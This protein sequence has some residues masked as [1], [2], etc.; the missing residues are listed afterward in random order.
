LIFNVDE[1]SLLRRPAG[2]YR[3]AYYLRENNWDAEVIDFTIFWP[4]EKLKQL[5]RQRMSD[6]VKFIGFSYLFVDQPLTSI[7][8]F[9]EWIKKEYPNVKIL[10]GSPNKYRFNH[11]YIDYN[12]DGF[13][14]IALLE[15]LK[16]LFSNGSRPAFTLFS[17]AGKNISANKN[18]PAFP[19]SN[20]NII[21]EDRDFLESH[22]WLGI[23]FSR[24]CKF[25]CAFCNYPV[26]G[27]KGDYSRD[28]EDFDS[29]MRN[30]YDRFG[31]TKY[32]VADETF[33]DRTE[34]ITKFADVVEKLNFQ[35]FFTGCVRGDLLVK[36][37]ADRE[38]LLRMNFLGQ[39]YGIES[40]HTESAKAIGKGM[41]SEKIK[42]G[43]VDVR[44]YFESHGTK[45]YRG[46]ISLIA[47]LPHESI[48][49]LYNTRDWLLENWKGQN[50]SM[51][52]LEIPISEFD[53]PSKIGL[54]WA[55]YGYQDAANDPGMEN[56]IV[57]K[58]ITAKDYLIWKNQHMTLKDAQ[59]VAEEIQRIRQ[60]T[61]NDF[62]AGVYGIIRIGLPKDI[63]ELLKVKETDVRPTFPQMFIDS[64]IEKKLNL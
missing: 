24:G 37:P 12:I 56:I 10:L 25:S 20:L 1:G 35:P 58:M 63:D 55:K 30:A 14:E 33:N 32:Y 7:D 54:D 46:T 8:E 5:I 3:I 47:G 11:S 22:E 45:R 42:T 15:L 62:R 38:E 9:G 2:A 59:N 64:Y 40:F 51:L 16:Y 23:E 29:Q 57:R 31:I 18:Y 43:L 60:D 44:K 4:L 49:S 53:S 50:F 61:E 34:K 13:G 26:L 27:V 36:R 21:Y 52:P 17:N 28:A 19:M 39:L 41:D 48:E 6:D